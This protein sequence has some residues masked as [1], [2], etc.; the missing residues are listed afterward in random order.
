[1]SFAVEHKQRNKYPVEELNL[2]S[3]KESETALQKISV[4]HEGYFEMFSLNEKSNLIRWITLFQFQGTYLKKL[5]IK[6][7]YLR[8]EWSSLGFSAIIFFCTFAKLSLFSNSRDDIFQ[9]LFFS[10][11]IVLPVDNIH[12]D[13][14]L[15]PYRL[16]VLTYYSIVFRSFI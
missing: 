13:S 16:T 5:S 15:E 11:R 6:Y 8:K 10:T 7:I 14:A 1:M 12:V 2:R 4:L 3:T 9:S